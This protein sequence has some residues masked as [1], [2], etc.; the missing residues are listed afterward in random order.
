[1]TKALKRLP[2]L[3]KEPTGWLL[4][5]LTAG[6]FYMQWPTRAP[7]IDQP[8]YVTQQVSTNLSVTWEAQPE[9]TSIEPEVWVL[10]RKR[11]IFMVQKSP[12]NKPFGQW[13]EEMAEQD[14]KTVAG[15][16]LKPIEKSPT[17]ASYAF[18]DAEGRT[19]E[20]RIYLDG[21]DWIKVSMLYKPSLETRV[22]RAAVFLDGIEWQL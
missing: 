9:N 21:S 8:D 4:I 14:R 18:Y 3:L 7:K 10:E 15:A 12:L 16:V 20:H 19:Q 6:F 17:R 11:M 5:I 2:R 13:V 1:M 22:T